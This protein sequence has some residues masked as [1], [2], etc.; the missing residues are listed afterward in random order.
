MRVNETIGTARHGQKGASF[1]P[2]RV[3]IAGGGTGGHLFPAVAIAHE[4]LSVNR[5]NRVLFVSTGN[6][7]EKRTLAKEGLK[8]ETIPA[9][10][11][12]GRGLW[13]QARA[14][15]KI[16]LGIFISMRILKRFR[17]DLILGV[18]S[19]AAGPV[20]V[21][22]Y[23]M[24]CRIVLHEQN[25]LPG[26]TNRI[27]ARFADRVFISFEKT[28]RRLP[29]KKAEMTGNPVRR[30]ILSGGENRLEGKIQESAG[31]P[32]TVLILGGSQGAHAINLAMA[33][34]AGLLEE[35]RRYRLVHQ[36][37]A[38]DADFVA[39]AY[40]KA[41]VTH[42][43]KPFFEN[44]ADAYR[45]A[46]LVVCRAGAT[47]VAEVTALG[48]PVLFIPFPHAA[49]N[50]QVLNARTL[51]DNRAADMI[52]ERDATGKRLADAITYY[53]SH[54]DRLKQM[55]ADTRQLGHP[56]AAEKIV[57]KCYRLLKAD[58]GRPILRT[59]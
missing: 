23:L 34:A 42:R 22:G 44:M 33:E 50:H 10:G 57:Q 31:D 47:T 6:A 52:E 4:F 45:M 43:V 46:D 53:R 58:R 40:R 29:E 16:P 49:D 56:D 13:R 38:K 1:F 9:E 19:Y 17:P 5:E 14:A 2:M 51:S 8:L 54:P 26:V 15:L 28:R 25:L 7:F 24:G 36:T 3:V 59:A 39:K 41:G 12:K 18:G 35:K 37:G 21:G 11:I 30:S 55:A 48:K 32:F 20:S 27:L